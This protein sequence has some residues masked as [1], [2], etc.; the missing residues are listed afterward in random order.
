MAISVVLTGVD[1]FGEELW[2]LEP[3]WWDTSALFS[4]YQNK[5]RPSDPAPAW[6]I[7]L[8]PEEVRSLAQRFPIRMDHQEA[9]S[10]EL[11]RLLRGDARE[12]MMLLFE[13]GS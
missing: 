6:Q 11:N 3:T 10:D 8:S 13:W 4:E 2:D 9:K 7:R 5:A 1:G 12:V